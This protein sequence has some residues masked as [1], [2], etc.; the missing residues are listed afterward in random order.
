MNR[1][2]IGIIAASIATLGLVGFTTVLGLNQKAATVTEALNRSTN[3]YV[4]G[5]WDNFTGEST[6]FKMFYDGETEDHYYLY[7]LTVTFSVGDTFQV[8]DKEH[9]V[10]C[11]WFAATDG[12][13]GGNASNVNIEVT[14]AGRYTLHYKYK[15]INTKEIYKIDS[16]TSGKNGFFING[17][18]WSDVYVHSW[19]GVDTGFPGHLAEYTGA[20][21]NGHGL[22][23][24][25][26]DSANTMVQFS[27]GSNSRQTGDLSFVQGECWCFTVTGADYNPVGK[28][29]G[30]LIEYMAPKTYLANTYRQSI[31]GIT[32]SEASILV[33]LY[34]GLSET[35]KGIADVSTI[36]T[37]DVGQGGTATVLQM[38]PY[39]RSLA[40]GGTS[41]GTVNASGFANAT[42]AM[43]ATAALGVAAAAGIVFVRKRKLI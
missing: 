5:S 6:A 8:H 24:F 10:W 14:K 26:I 36:A 41:A 2:K 7:H 4:K 37:N 23:R 31:C 15:D 30:N 35:S 42:T 21:V 12:F 13:T 22:F 18:G 20:L 9:N 34:D 16:G 39:I 32:Q 25:E 33:G 27:N 1:K 11:S 38:M 28:L 3:I 19:G 40:N 17:D 29:V 43:V